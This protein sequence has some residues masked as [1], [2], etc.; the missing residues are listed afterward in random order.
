MTDQIKNVQDIK[1]I[2]KIYTPMQAVLGS[3]L[4]GPAAAI[5]YISK[6]YYAFGNKKAG[7]ITI[8]I[9]SSIIL[10]AAIAVNIFFEAIPSTAIPIATMLSA[11]FIINREHISEK[12]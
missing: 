11:H 6:N 1:P 8:I 5:Y 12:K 4:G 7:K 2:S 10:I 9:G 3:L